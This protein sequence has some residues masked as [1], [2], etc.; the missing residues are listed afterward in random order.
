[1][2][3][4]KEDPRKCKITTKPSK[5]AKRTSDL[6]RKRDPVLQLFSKK[7]PEAKL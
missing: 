7:L 3:K 2:H 6:A 4:Y 1:V 5:S